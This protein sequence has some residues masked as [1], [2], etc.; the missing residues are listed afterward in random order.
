MAQPV[1]ANPFPV[2]LLAGLGAFAVITARPPGRR[3]WLWAGCCAAWP[4]RGGWTSACT[5]RAPPAWRSCC[6]RRPPAGARAE[7]LRFAATAVAAGLVLYAPFLIAAGPAEM[8]DQL[9]ATAGRERDYWTLPFPLGYD[10]AFSL[11]PPGTA[12]ERAKDVLGFYV[13]LLVLVG[14]ALAAAAAAV[15]GAPAAAWLAG[16]VALGAGGAVYMFSRADEFHSAPG[17]VALAL[18]LPVCVVRRPQ[19]RA[20]PGPSWPPPAWRCWC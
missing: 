10:G 17:V 5:R 11:W 3:P 13:P 8:Y 9:V 18:A 6:A 7:A 4:R 1:S 2:A 19:A 20:A 15:A 14:V 16:A 12:A